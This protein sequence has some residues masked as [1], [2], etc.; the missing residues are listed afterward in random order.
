MSGEL[1]AQEDAFRARRNGNSEVTSHLTAF[2]EIVAR[3]VRWAWQDR[4]ALAKITALAGRPKI[5]KGLLYS[6]LIAE[7][8]RGCLP[9]DLDGP[10]DAILVTTEDE[11]GDTLKPRLMAADAD[12]VPRLDLPDGGQGRAG[13]VPGAAGRGRAWAA[14]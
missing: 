10:R 3:P 9:G 4:A 12:L 13:A 7:V 6:H 2:E 14:G 5:G 8:T 11:P 1:R